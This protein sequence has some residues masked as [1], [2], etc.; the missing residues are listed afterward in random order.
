MIPHRYTFTGILKRASVHRN[1]LRV[2]VNSQKVLDR[3]SLSL[4]YLTCR[5]KEPLVLERREFPRTL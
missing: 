1:D 3:L 4:S 2:A 5:R